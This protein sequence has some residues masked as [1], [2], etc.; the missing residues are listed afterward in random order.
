M[1]QGVS[2]EHLTSPGTTLGTVAYMSPEQVRGKELDVRTDLFSFGVVLY[3]MA[4]G[5]LPFRGESSGAIFNAIL[6]R[7]PVPTVRLN[8]DLPPKLED[9][10]NRALEK[11]RELRYQHASEMRSELMRLKRDSDSDRGLYSGSKV[12]RD[13]DIGPATAS[14]RAATQPS[15]RHTRKLHITLAACGAL[16]VA[17]FVGY[18]LW[19]RTNIPSGP[20]R[21]TQI[22]RWNKPLDD[23]RLS[24]DGH[25][26][27]FV[28]PISGI[29]Q[30]FLMLTSGGEPLQ[31]TNDEGDKD[32]DSF[33]PDGKEIYY[34]KNLGRD[35]TWAVPTLGGSPRRLVAARWMV[36][37]PDGASIF[38]AKSEAS[39][40]FRAGKSGLNEE[41][42]Y[43]AKGTGLFF[44]PMLLYPGDNDLLAGGFPVAFE[45][46]FRFFKINLTS[47]AAVDLGE[48]SANAFD[49]VWAEP[50]KT[51][52]FGRAVNGLMNVWSYH[53][54]DR[55]LTQ[56]TFGTGPDYAP[57]P[58]PGG[59]GIYFVNGKSS[60]S[61]AA[62]HVHSK[63]S[64]DIAEDA[65]GPGISPDGKRVMYVT[66]PSTHG[67]ELWVSDIDGGNKF[68]VATG[69][70][71]WTGSWAPDN[72]HVT[73]VDSAPGAG[74]KAYIAG[75]DGSGLHQL[76]QMGGIPNNP[77]W[78][79][80]QKSLYVSVDE[81]ATTISTV[82][83]WSMEARIQKRSWTTVL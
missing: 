58:D 77:V 59:R 21:I 63:E 43:N 25:A 6:E 40:I 16:L 35:E 10:I 47:H 27:A 42:V 33:S 46:K 31:L 5:T 72:F 49:A 55:S 26:V 20:A 65:T 4:T 74:A 1:T 37:S 66:F 18:Y 13:S 39:G 56:I 15:E 75:T 30:V 29:T 50:G 11:D 54:N 9:I 28:S 51:V 76:P 83:K 8:P 70:G 60:G 2:A 34:Q 38:Y 3:E 79:P 73:F 19:P 12:V 44:V 24:P 57:M 53:L 80:D 45:S 82:W 61:L 17:C 67:S 14:T 23:A 41:L 52:L 81:K 64:T 69:D 36:P 71:L 68:K 62:Y 78:S 32:I 48:V 22:S 7:Q